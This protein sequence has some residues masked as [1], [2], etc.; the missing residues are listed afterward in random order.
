MNIETF[1][2]NFDGF[3]ETRRTY[4]SKKRDLIVQNISNPT[5]ENIQELT[6]IRKTFANDYQNFL[7][8]LPEKLK[9]SFYFYD[10]E[11]FCNYFCN[12]LEDFFYPIEEDLNNPLGPLKKKDFYK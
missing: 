10:D 11:D 6:N 9:S 8:S 7:N 5:L 12:F 1:K 4:I 2:Q 3:N